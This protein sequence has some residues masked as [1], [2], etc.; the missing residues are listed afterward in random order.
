MPQT[1]TEEM[2]H[3]L[4]TRSLDIVEKE[5]LHINVLLPVIEWHIEEGK[6]LLDERDCSPQVVIFLNILTNTLVYLKNYT[7]LLHSME[8]IKAA[9]ALYKAGQGQKPSIYQ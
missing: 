9:L 4:L 2:M 8:N 5:P 6:K 7:T 3:Q 1:L